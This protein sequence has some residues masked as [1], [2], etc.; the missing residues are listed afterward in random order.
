MGLLIPLLASWIFFG[1][2]GTSLLTLY[3][4][5][6]HFPQEFDGDFPTIS[7]AA[8]F[9]AT[10]PAFALGMGSVGLCVAVSWILYCAY[11]RRNIKRANELHLHW[12][13]RVGLLLGV[14]QG[15]S[16]FF[17]GVFS[18]RS[19]HDIHMA[20]SYGAFISGTLAILVDGLGTARWRLPDGGPS[21]RLRNLRRRLSVAVAVFGSVFLFM[22]V[23]KNSNP[24]GDYHF[25]RLVYGASEIL[26]S[27]ASFSYAP[28]AGLE[29]LIAHRLAK[30]T[31]RA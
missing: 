8:S 21:G 22:F 12:Y 9:D 7:Y 17:M 20:A 14:T 2:V 15:V 4:F 27:T 11:N 5:Y 25:T 28:L 24:L 18:L 30:A 6:R 10:E 1:G 3:T 16:V 29:M 26:F 31:S 13:N 23:T 19:G